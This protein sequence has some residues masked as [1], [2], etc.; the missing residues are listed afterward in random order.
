MFRFTQAAGWRRRR[1]R[2]PGKGEPSGVLRT[3]ACTCWLFDAP[4]PTWDLF[5]LPCRSW[6]PSYR[7]SLTPSPCVPP[8]GMPPASPRP[9]ATP[10][11]N[12]S[13]RD[14]IPCFLG[15][16]SPA[17]R[18]MQ[19]LAASTLHCRSLEQHA[20]LSHRLSLPARPFLLFAGQGGGGPPPCMGMGCGG[21]GGGGGGGS[22][23]NCFAKVLFRLKGHLVVQCIHASW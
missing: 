12:V 6:P 4:L 5:N 2:L 14:G 20:K 8:P 13:G 3:P 23:D 17:Q 18:H 11:P 16:R 19:R 15:C 10:W 9:R 21:G 7:P 1:A 22:N